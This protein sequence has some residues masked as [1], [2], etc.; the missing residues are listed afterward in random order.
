MVGS[1]VWQAAPCKS[2]QLLTV[3]KHRIYSACI[4]NYNQSGG[5]TIR[6]CLGKETL[7][8]GAEWA[9]GRSVH[10]GGEEKNLD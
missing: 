10:T 3:F 9:L 2:L 5:P 4:R 8:S 6:L 1:L 7:E